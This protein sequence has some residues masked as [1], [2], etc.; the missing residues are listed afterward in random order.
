MPP[1]RRLHIGSVWLREG[2][3]AG[4]ARSGSLSRRQGLRWAAG[5]AGLALAGCARQPTLRRLALVPARLSVVVIG[6]LG[7]AGQPWLNA[8]QSAADGY[9]RQ[10]GTPLGLDVVATPV[11]P[12]DWYACSDPGCTPGSRS[13]RRARP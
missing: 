13:S 3:P 5:A 9:V 6:F 8:L 7:S 4:G 11:P 2:R 1:V 10:R 12:G